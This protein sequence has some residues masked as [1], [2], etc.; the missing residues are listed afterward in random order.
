MVQFERRVG[1]GTK[2]VTLRG[3]RCDRCGYTS[4]DDDSDIWGTVG[5]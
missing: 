2:E 4:L 3:V 1:T 5:L